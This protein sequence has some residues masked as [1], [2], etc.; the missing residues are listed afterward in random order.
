MQHVIIL[1]IF[2]K[3]SFFQVILLCYFIF[4]NNIV[5]L[6]LFNIFYVFCNLILSLFNK[7][8]IF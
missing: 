5:I 7:S 2:A 1:Y 3:F 6:L 4:T 8:V